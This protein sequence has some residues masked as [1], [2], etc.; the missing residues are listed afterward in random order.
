MVRVRAE[1]DEDSQVMVSRLALFP[2]LPPLLFFGIINGS[3]RALNY[4]ERKEQK[5]GRPGKECDFA[6][7]IRT[8]TVDNI[9]YAY[10]WV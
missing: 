4:T 7:L 6:S 8:Y 2:G 10:T 9:I 5:R 3:R 1:G